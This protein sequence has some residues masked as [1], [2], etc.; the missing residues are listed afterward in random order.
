MADNNKPYFVTSKNFHGDNDYVEWLKEI[1][2]RYQAIRNRVVMQSNYGALE[3]NWLLGRDIVQKRAE[4]RWGSGTV[5][6]LCL[7]LK[8]AYP[9]VKGFSVRNLY[10]MKEWYEFYMAD[11]EH[12]EILHQVGA[13]LQEAENQN[14]IKLHQ[15]GA[16]IVSADKISAI[17]AEGGMLPVFGIVPWKH[18]LT[19]ISKCKSIKEAFYYM[20]R[21]IDEGLSK[22]ELE[23]VID[24]DDFSK[25]GNAL[26]NFSSQLSTS[27]SLLAC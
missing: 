18:H 11:E 8:A 25:Y 5:N 27:Q 17:L 26:T 16:E 20:A 21:V 2:S 13:K 4:S 23:D 22:R 10:Y 24:N 14:P 7:D 12:K 3:F 19:L 15:L 6:Q 1:K 9:D